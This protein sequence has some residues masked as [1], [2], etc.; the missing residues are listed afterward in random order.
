ML[1][2]NHRL[3]G[4]QLSSDVSRTTVQLSKLVS[5]SGLT[6][7]LASLH[8]LAEYAF[9]NAVMAAAVS[10]S[11]QDTCRAPLHYTTSVTALKTSAQDQVETLGTMHS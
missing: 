9:K 7:L 2:L 1:S 5:I 6:R 11:I 3:A 8:Y 4:P 10:F